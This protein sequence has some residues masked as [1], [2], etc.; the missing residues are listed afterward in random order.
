L[1]ASIK[2]HNESA[3][4]QHQGSQFMENQ[5]IYKNMAFPH[6][7]SFSGQGHYVIHRQ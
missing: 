3:E 6:I 5:N 2:D 4:K 7:M 1:A